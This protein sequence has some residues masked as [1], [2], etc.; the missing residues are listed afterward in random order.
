ML[1]DIPGWPT[2]RL[3]YLLLDV[4][5]TLTDRGALLP[6][7]QSRLAV[8]QE[9]L[10]VRL[11][12]A[13]TYGTATRTAA[14][15]GGVAVQRVTDGQQ[16]A[17]VA[18]QLGKDRCVAVGNGANDEAL[19]TTVA[20][21]IAVLGREGASTRAVLAADVLCLSIVDALDLLTDPR[22]LAATLRS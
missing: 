22:A 18:E 1:L 9:A 16:K 2:Q 19:L 11:L 21:G 4:N 14:D 8:L 3:D 13:D 7:V 17:A 6:E 20:L 5:G 12:T 10:D 15:L